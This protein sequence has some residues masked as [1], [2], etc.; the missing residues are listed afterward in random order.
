[1]ENFY[2]SHRHRVAVSADDFG[3]SPHANAN[4]LYLIMLG[5]INRVGVMVHGEIL[6]NEIRELAKSGVKI[7]IHLDILHKFNGDRKKRKST[8]MRIIEFIAKLISGRISSQKIENEWRLQIEKFREKFGKNPDG[9][10]SHEHVHF[11]PPFFKIAL[12]LCD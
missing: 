9:I 3:I 7:D 2:N 8:L 11:F 12:K 10:N 1:M 4:A 5:K 6:D